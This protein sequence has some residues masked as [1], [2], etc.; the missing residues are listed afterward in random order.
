LQRV[1]LLIAA[2][3]SSNRSYA[4]SFYEKEFMFGFAQNNADP[5]PSRE[6]FDE[7]IEGELFKDPPINR[8]FLFWHLLPLENLSVDYGESFD[9]S[10]D[11]DYYV[12]YGL[13]MMDVRNRRRYDQGDIKFEK[14]AF[15]LN[16]ALGVTISTESTHVEYF[17]ELWSYFPLVSKMTFSSPQ[18]KISY[19]GSYDYFGDFH[20]NLAG[21]VRYR[22]SPQFNVFGTGFVGAGNDYGWLWGWIYKIPPKKQTASIN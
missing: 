8:R 18:G 16:A 12:G 2:V 21:G 20:V 9:D 13:G 3:L 22:V 6:R 19:E 4:F 15:S 5:L 10:M 7:E 1:F 14:I 11:Y 17:L